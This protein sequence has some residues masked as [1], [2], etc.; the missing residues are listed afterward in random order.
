[1]S[2]PNL[3]GRGYTALPA[4]A[5]LQQAIQARNDAFISGV[6]FLARPRPHILCLVLSRSCR[7]PP[8]FSRELVKGLGPEVMTNRTI[9]VTLLSY[10]LVPDVVAFSR[11]LADGQKLTSGLSAPG[12]KIPPLNVRIYLS[13]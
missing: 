3:R 11:D 9:A 4:A 7:T 1:M 6:Q 5:W 10:H 8:A 2:D 12:S 13:Q